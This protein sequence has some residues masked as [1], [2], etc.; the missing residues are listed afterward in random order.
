MFEADCVHQ[1]KVGLDVGPN[2]CIVERLGER[3]SAAD[4]ENP[5]GVVVCW[6]VWGPSTSGWWVVLNGR[7]VEAVVGGGC[8]WCWPGCP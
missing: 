6:P 4:E 5:G 3:T 7:G 1:H 8:G 2:E